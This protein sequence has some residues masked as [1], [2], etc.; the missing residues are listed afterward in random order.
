MSVLTRVQRATKENR[1]FVLAILTLSHGV[2]HFYQQSFLVLLPKIAVDLG[3]SGVRVGALGTVRH[4]TSFSIE[5]PGGF[6]IDMLKHRWGMIFAGCMGLIAVAWAVTG[7][8]P[9]FTVLV[10]AVALIA[11][12]GT[13]WHLPAMASLSQRFPERRG[14]AVSVHGLGGNLGNILG[15]L[16]AGMLLGLLLLTWR[17]VAFLYAVPPLIMVFFLWVSLQNVGGQSAG[18]EQGLRTRLNSAKGLIKS[19]AVRGLVLVAMLRGMGFDALTLF[20]PIYLANEL[21]MGDVLVGF[22]IALLTA[23]G[24]IALPMLGS[25]SDKFGR[26]VVLL[27]GLMAMALLSFAIVNV[28]SGLA[29]TLVIAGMGIFSYSLNQIIRAAVLDLAPLG[30]EATSYGLVFGSTQVFAAFSPLVA[31]AL[32]DWLGIEFVFYYAAILVAFSAFL[33]FACPLHRQEMINTAAG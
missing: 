3:L 2:T 21:K 14:L 4:L 19:P 32:K 29:L 9:N 6:I 26:K 23:L 22:H 30:S 24:V 18:G 7:A 13:V 5:V 31:G 10:I 25:L 15:P 11:L 12:P 17:Q 27:P 1:V 16:A 28:G 33:L 20:T 8:T